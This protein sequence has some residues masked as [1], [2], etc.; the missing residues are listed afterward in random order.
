MAFMKKKK[1]NTKLYTPVYL[2]T[3]GKNLAGLQE[4]MNTSLGE[5]YRQD[6]LEARLWLRH[7]LRFKNPIRTENFCIVLNLEI[8]YIINHNVSSKFGQIMY[9]IIKKFLVVRSDPIFESKH[10]ML[11]R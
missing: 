5:W 6:L 9:T 11:F 8:I 1:Y 7:I 2:C 4:M 3:Y 10:E